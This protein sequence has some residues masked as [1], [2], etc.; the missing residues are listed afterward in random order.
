MMQQPTACNVKR[1]Q[2]CKIQYQGIVNFK[3]AHSITEIKPVLY[4]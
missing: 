2:T 4:K 3:I 1:Q